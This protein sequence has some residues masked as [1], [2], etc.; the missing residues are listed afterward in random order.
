M[1]ARFHSR[2][3][4]VG[5]VVNLWMAGVLLFSFLYFVPGPTD[6]NARARIDTTI[7]LVNHESFA[8]DQYAWNTGD[9]AY[10]R[11]H[12]YSNKVPG[13]SLAGV[14]IMLAYKAVL[15][16]L[17][18]GQAVTDMGTRK[19]IRSGLMPY[20][21]LMFFMTLATVTLPA[22]FMLM[23]FSWFLRFFSSSYRN[24]VILTLSLGLATG[25][26]PY[27]HNVY[28]HVPTAALDFTSFVL[29]FVL[30]HGQSH[31]EG[32]VGWAQAH[33]RFT[34]ALG[35]FLLGLGILFEYPAAVAFVL[36]GIYALRVLPGRLRAP[37]VGGAVIGP[38]ATLICAYVA[39]GN[40]LA[41]GYTQHNYYA[42]KQNQG[43]GGFTWPPAAN[44]IWG[45]TLS[46]YRG[47][48][49]LSPFLLFAIPGAVLMLRRNR[50]EAL[51]ACGIPAL[52]VPIIAMFAYWNGG[53]DTVGPRLLILCLP[54]L[55]LPAIA[56]MDRV[57][58][59]AA[60]L[61]MYATFLT[62]AAIVWTESLGYTGSPPYTHNPLFVSSIP[63]VA[64]GDVTLNM[65]SILL[66]PVGGLHS[67]WS[68]V[69]LPV[70]LAA[71]TLASY[72][73]FRRASTDRHASLSADALNPSLAK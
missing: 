31:P 42:P 50:R 41:T 15:T 1:S 11:G 63:A 70:G 60:C 20:Y 26:L 37:F 67:L 28:S 59:R 45:L 57:T 35:G 7:A 5:S 8:I 32:K 10:A 33:P 3:T 34:A 30:A 36:L 38:A 49:F 17:G 51:V 25:I 56:F 71:W 4:S 52:L 23:V 24:R 44:A 14:P 73:R 46:P 29:V 13:Q 12:W 39:Y 16:A 58:H 65:G 55:A 68:L 40:V 43:I 48:F 61:G 27:A 62:S 6:L 69:F 9:L 21:M 47:L 18:Q 64:R 22:V 2:H 66:A 53:S 72:Q 19:S 54:F